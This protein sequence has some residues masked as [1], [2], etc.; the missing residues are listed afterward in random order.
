MVLVG[1]YLFKLFHVLILCSGFLHPASAAVFGSL[2]HIWT[3]WGKRQQRKWIQSYFDSWLIIH[4]LFLVKSSFY[5]Q[6]VQSK[7]LL[8]LMY[9]I[10]F[11]FF[12]PS[13]GWTEQ[14]IW[15][16]HLRVGETNEAIVSFKHLISKGIRHNYP[17]VNLIFFSL[18]AVKEPTN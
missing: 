4:S 6:L 14:A 9:F 15:R 11:Y 17:D 7:Y 8:V 5:F 13:V 12:F 18:F 3:A 1:L 16:H 2:N 10:L